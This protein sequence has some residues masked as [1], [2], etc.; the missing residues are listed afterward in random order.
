MQSPFGISPNPNLLYV[1]QAI[2]G[3]LEK[4]RFTIA[5]R[6]GL[7]L[8]LGDNG[9]GKSSVL[10]F[11]LAEYDAAGCTTGLLVQTE[12]PSKYAF[13]KA[14][15]AQFRLEPRR[16][17]VA[18]HAAFEEW[19]VEEYKAGRNVVLFIDEAQRLNAELL[20]II[21]ALLNF[22]TYTDK[23]LQIVMGGTLEL[24]DR[25]LAKRNKALRSR[26]FAPCMLNPLSSE[27][28]A[29]MIAFRCQRAGIKNP[30][31]AEGC[32]RIFEF[33]R[34]VPRHALTIAAHAWNMSKRLKYT[35]VPPD[36]VEAAAHEC[37][38]PEEEAATA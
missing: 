22:E 8:L 34:G 23:L 21:R 5:E 29:R 12:Y 20:E 3:H 35:T 6:Q 38:V 16:S 13:L 30:F 10:R 31:D 11:L 19:L 36:L 28:T 26:I 4:I 7:A 24:R 27:E 17:Q 32:A 33:S 2:F 15:C 37:E 14:I 9:V 25:I 1:T 18:Q